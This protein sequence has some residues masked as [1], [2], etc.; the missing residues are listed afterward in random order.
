MKGLKK[1]SVIML[2]VGSVFM[3]GC[4][5]TQI[6]EMIGKIADGVQQAMPA[7]KNIVDTFSNIFGNKGD[8][9]ANDAAANNNAAAD[10]AAGTDAD[11][12]GNAN[13]VVLD[14]NK[15]EVTGATPAAP[16][17]TGA[18]DNTIAADKQTEAAKLAEAAKK[19]EE[20]KKAE[21]A[22][23]AE[24][25]NQKNPLKISAA[26]QK[27]M[28]AVVAYA[29][30]NNTGASKGQCF[31]AVWGYLTKSGYGKLNDWKDLPDMGD[32][33]ARCF[34]EFLNASQKNLDEA[35]LKRLDN[36]LTPP[37]TSPHDKRIP[38]G[39]VI[40]VGP[41]ST[42]TSHATAGDIVI[43]AGEGHFIND[44]PNMNY[45]TSASWEGKILGVYIPK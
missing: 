11:A 44:G 10:A 8:A 34:P 33:E 18:A 20:A 15:E 3:T 35:G 21:A 13:V 2:L 6:V 37:I 45:G 4:D 9:N 29:K 40:V 14:P 43:K 38:K 31:A 30:A 12:K 23:L 24:A 7:I 41:G 16:T 17:E 27:Q 22:K 5:A 19:A 25:A 26:A 1:F 28:N 32:G 42:G 36:T 39:A